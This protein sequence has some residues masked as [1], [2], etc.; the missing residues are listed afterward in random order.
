MAG[1]FYTGY[2]FFGACLMAIL[3]KGVAHMVGKLS[4]NFLSVC[5]PNYTSGALVFTRRV[6]SGEEED[7]VKASLSFPAEY[8]SHLSFGFF[9]NI[10]IVYCI[11]QLRK[12]PMTRVLCLFLLMA[13]AILSSL[14][15]YTEG[16][17]H[18]VDVFVGIVVG[19]TSAAYIVFD[20]LRLFGK[21]RS[22]D[23]DMRHPTH[24]QQ[25]AN[26]TFDELS[27]LPYT[28]LQVEMDDQ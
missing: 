13:V 8:A 19:V 2:F 25:T 3:N 22:P 1:L 5:K 11:P 24:T 18:L 7:I 26:I 16:F 10:A 14:T 20:S 12:V 17:N 9:F 27:N 23:G 4:P 28:D 21:L 6:C 15:R